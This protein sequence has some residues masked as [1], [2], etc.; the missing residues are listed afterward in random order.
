MASNTAGKTADSVTNDTPL[1]SIIETPLTDSLINGIFQQQ[2]NDGSF[3]ATAHLGQLFNVDFE[4]IK[5]DLLAKG[6][7][8][9]ISDEIL[10]LISTASI[11]FYILYH[12]QKTNFPID[13]NAIKQYVSKAREELEGFSLKDD[14]IMQTYIEKGELA[15]NYVI[16]IREKYA[17]ICNQIKLS[18]PTWEYYVQ[19]LMGLDKEQQ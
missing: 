19:H 5:R 18:Q 8:P 10:R 17:D 3:T 2:N 13:L 16:N 11:L 1:Q 15:V 14:P 12:S 6:L 7:E 9:S 4:H